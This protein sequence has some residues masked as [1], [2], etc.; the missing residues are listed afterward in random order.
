MYYPKKRLRILV[1]LIG[2]YVV[3]PQTINPAVA[4]AAIDATVAAAG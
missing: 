2:E 1:I 3:V 4:S